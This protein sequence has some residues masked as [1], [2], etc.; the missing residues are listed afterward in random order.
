MKSLAVLCPGFAVD[1][2]ETLEE[3][4]IE[5]R[6]QFLEAGGTEFRYI[7]CLNSNS[8]QLDAL[9]TLVR[10]QSRGWPEFD[11]D[12]PASSQTLASA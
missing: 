10:R 12:A 4:A 9:E 6:R 11:D 1:C 5:G 3:I 2:L 7:E 8:D